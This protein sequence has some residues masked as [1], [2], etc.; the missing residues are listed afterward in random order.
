MADNICC[1]NAE[2]IVPAASVDVMEIQLPSKARGKNTAYFACIPKGRR[3]PKQLP[4][5][6]LL[7]GAWDSHRAWM[8]QAGNQLKK[9]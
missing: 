2:L 8:D 7:H 4:V 1:V 6:Y 5:L 9:K 3:L